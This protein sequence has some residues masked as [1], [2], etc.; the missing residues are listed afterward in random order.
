[1]LEEQNVCSRQDNRF[2][3]SHDP[4]VTGGLSRRENVS[5]KP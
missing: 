5:D 3:L 1:M 4:V 2:A